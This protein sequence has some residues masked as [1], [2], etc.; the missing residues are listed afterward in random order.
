MAKVLRTFEKGDQPSTNG[1]SRKGYLN[2]TYDQLVDRLGEPTIDEPSG[3]NKTQVE[4]VVAYGDD[5]FTVYDWK[6]YDREYTINAL[7]R[8]NV[9]GTSYA[10]DFISYLESRI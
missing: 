7:G 8:F 6:T 10:G 3:D 5:I 9:G 4:W 2:L 1:A